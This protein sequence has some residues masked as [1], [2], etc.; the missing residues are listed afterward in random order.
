MISISWWLVLTVGIPESLLMI[1]MGFQLY[2]LEV[3]FNNA[4]AI[5]GI[6][7]VTSY[8][9]RKLP[10]MF[11]LHS[12]IGILVLMS[13]CWLFTRYPFRKVLYS[14]LSGFAVMAVTQTVLLPICLALISFDYE[15]VRL[16]P[17]VESLIFSVQAI[18]VGIAYVQF[19][20][21]NIFI[22]DLSDGD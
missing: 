16:Y 11:G 18:A 2:N 5:A 4:L 3:R 12:L 17:G 1:L 14:V 9:V 19:R 6:S 21:H 10:I 7:A 20:K 15:T 13:L 22:I 8:L